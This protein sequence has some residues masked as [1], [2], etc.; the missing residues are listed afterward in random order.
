L[1]IGRRPLSTEGQ[2]GAI[3]KA[4]QAQDAI[5][6]EV[7]FTEG[8]KTTANLTMGLTI[9]GLALVCGYYIVN[10]LMPSKMAPNTVFNNAL[11]VVKS[12]DELKAAIGAPIKGYGRDNGGKRTGRRNFVENKQFKDE[13]GIIHTRVRF[14]AEGPRGKAVIYADVS[15][16]AGKGEFYY[17]IIEVPKTNKRWAI[18]DNRPRV[19]KAVRQDEVATLLSNRAGAVLYGSDSDEWTKKQ[20]AE[21]GEAFK[22][23]KFVACDKDVE[24]C[25][26]MG[27]SFVPQWSIKGQL[28]EPGFR[29]LSDLQ[30]LASEQVN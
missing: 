4:E 16:D 20:M 19:P 17:L 11:D 30:V 9:A 15:K 2:K 25:R 27:V 22:R 12:N 8:V 28:L 24:H 1:R 6:T 3:E 5:S 7:T 10:E 29:S 26:K 18:H 23:I 21:F 13:D 14:N